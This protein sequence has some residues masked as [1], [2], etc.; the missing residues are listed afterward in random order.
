MSSRAASVGDAELDFDVSTMK[1]VGRLDDT[2]LIELVIGCPGGVC[3]WE[4]DPSWLD[5]V[6]DA[7]QRS[8]ISLPA[9]PPCLRE[10]VPSRSARSRQLRRDAVEDKRDDTRARR[11][12]R[13]G[14]HAEWTWAP[15]VRVL[16]VR[17]GACHLRVCTPR[18]ADYVHCHSSFGQRQRASEV[19]YALPPRRQR[20]RF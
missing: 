9:S 12:T 10:S 11:D 15:K 8:R 19:P 5:D 1:S 18:P 4:N 2:D 14:G 3:S 16:L 20:S 6:E 7:C 13:C 17:L